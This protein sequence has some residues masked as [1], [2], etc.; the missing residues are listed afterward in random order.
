M[1]SRRAPAGLKLRSVSPSYTVDDLQKS[2]A[3]YRDGLGFVVSDQ[4]EEGGKVMGVM[5]KAGNI[6]IGL[7]QDDFA[8]GRDREKGV[9]FRIHADAAQGVDALAKRIRAFGGKIITE[10]TDTS[11]GT[12]SFAVEDP[13]GFKISFSEPR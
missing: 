7:S 9:G 10:P 2:I 4:W 12:R 11:W 13:D 3:W 5:L 6:T 1:A 8:K